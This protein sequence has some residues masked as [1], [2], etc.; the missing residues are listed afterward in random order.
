VT[1]ENLGAKSYRQLQLEAIYREMVS[2]T[3]M[4]AGY[5]WLVSNKVRARQ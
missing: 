4:Q 5:V 1:G 2:V 3:E